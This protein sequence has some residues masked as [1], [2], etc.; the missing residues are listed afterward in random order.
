MDSSGALESAL[1]PYLDED[2]YEYISSLLEDDPFD[3]D[4]R[5][6]V[7]AL[8]HSATED[9]QVDGLQI[10]QNLF[11]LLD[12]GKNGDDDGEDGGNNTN[13]D[14]TGSSS[15]RK[16]DQAMTIKAYDIET[17][18]SG[19]RASQDPAA[20]DKQ[21]TEI[22]S[23][24]ANMI[25]ISSNEA[26]QSER[27]RRK[28]RQKEI[29]ERLE[30]E[31]RQ[32]AIQ[33]AMAQFEMADPITSSNNSEA[34]DGLM[35][36]AA[37]PNTSDVHCI[38]FDLPNL[39]GGGPNLLQNANLSLARGRRYGLMGRNGCGKTTFLTYLAQR[40]IDGAVPKHMNMLLVRQ[41]IMGNSW[42]AVE[43]VLKSDVKRESVK[44]YIEWC[45]QQLDILEK[46]GDQQQQQDQD[47]QEEEKDSKKESKGRQK[48]RDRKKLNMQKA[49]RQAAA[50]TTAAQVQESKEEKRKQLNAKLALAYE[51]LGQIEEE[52]GGDPE[53][54][55]RK[56]LAGLGFTTDMQDKPTSE[57]SGGWRMRVSLSCALFANPS[58]LLLD[59][60]TNHLDLEAVLWLERYLT[61]QF[62][63][64]LVV[65]SHDRHFLNEVVTDVVH[66]HRNTLTTYRGDISNF[67]AVRADDQL[68]QQRIYDQQEAKRAHLQK[69]IDLH[70]Q[71]GENGVKA[72]RQRKSKMKKLDKLGVMAQ[73]G[74]KWKAS[75]DGDAEEVEEV[76][77]E[78]KVVL[79]FPDPGSFEGDIIRLERAKF[80]YSPDKILLKDVDLTVTL[81]SRIALLGRNGCGKSTLIKLTVGALHPLGG[82]SIID[83]RA[84]IEY[85]AQHQL[86]QLDPDGTPLSTM[87]DRYPGD[88]GN[89]HIGELRRYLANFGLGGE[90]LPIQ[91]IHTMSGGQKCRLCLASAMYRKPHL[92]ILDEPTNH[93]D[94]E[95]TEALIEAI[96]TFQGGVLLVSHDQHL[97]TNVCDDLLVVENGHVEVL[98]DGSS[99]KDAFNAY[100]KAVIAGRR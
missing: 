13:N 82:K 87:I 8:I 26:A 93:L 78:E 52:E 25:D 59:E 71:S 35:E 54:R 38:D 63:G 53:P 36:K 7:A 15:L 65:V 3:D 14:T 18:A 98:R 49:A 66:F 44:R 6:A 67:E 57:L 43:T 94:L 97:L 39:R 99:N 32:R 85:L 40:Q 19:L 72:S 96:K 51:R 9:E 74:K 46:G 83:P 2:T 79:N 60:P 77:E 90:I 61:T 69:Y 76:Q 33:E 68:R 75:Y 20:D 50:S 1:L 34:A 41:E 28:A 23:F 70:A 37:I 58:L 42:T 5:E 12:M 86:E 62:A 48:L 17:F 91:K 56:V 4:A 11:E 22:A 89:T 45:E 100:K 10:C 73:D 30:E 64:T 92:L 31:E 16:L 29:R 80:G 84:K 24:Y 81:K 47:Q 95:T 27:L 21:E 88:R 55:A